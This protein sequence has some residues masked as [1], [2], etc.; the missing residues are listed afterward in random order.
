MLGRSG[1]RSSDPPFYF[2]YEPRQYLGDA[3]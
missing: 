2:L 3:I 1:K